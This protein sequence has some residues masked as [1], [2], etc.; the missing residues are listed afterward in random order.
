M[1]DNH[2]ADRVLQALTDGVVTVRPWQPDDAPAI[3]AAIEESR[4][5]LQQWLPAAGGVTQIDEVRA[6]IAATQELRDSGTA[7]DFV[8]ADARS[9][10]V[11]GGCG[12][13]QINRNHRFCN[14]YYWVRTGSA[15]RGVARRA[16]KLAARFGIEGI[17]LTRIEIVVEPEN[18]ASLHAAEG[19]GAR[20]EGLLRNRLTVHDQARDAVMLSLIPADFA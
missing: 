12:L 20:R 5:A 14:L 2:R 19:A 6:Y 3:F 16:I 15:R 10:D 13:T 17:G 7:Y 8:I 1:T 18:I 4:A 9:G 11:L